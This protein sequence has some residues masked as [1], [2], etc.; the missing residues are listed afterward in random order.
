MIKENGIN[1]II[2]Y[3]TN[4]INSKGYY[5][6]INLNSDSCR[7]SCSS[8]PEEWIN[9]DMLKDILF[10]LAKSEMYFYQKVYSIYKKK[11]GESL[12]NVS[13]VP[14]K[15]VYKDVYD[16]EI[17]NKSDNNIYVYNNDPIKYNTE[18]F[19]SRY[20][21]FYGIDED[22]EKMKV[23]KNYL[24]G[25][26]W[27]LGYYNNHIHSNWNWHYKYYAT[28]FVSDL[29]D[30]LTNNTTDFV[31]HLKKTHDLKK[32]SPISS[33]QQLYLVLPR[34][35]LLEILESIDIQLFYRTK[36]IFNTC[37]KMLDEYYPN[38][39]CLEM[40]H[41]EYLWQSKVFLKSIDPNFIQTFFIES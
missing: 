30:Y 17:I 27:I 33:L 14:Y 7:E 9:L 39:I 13:N 26:Y 24:T 11:S 2:K 3:Y 6:L 34:D 35:S 36:R 4:V 18:G 23:C 22:S 32:S 37:S 12:E 20:Y 5:S 8:N 21:K 25:L 10:Q 19:K 40:I 38:N 41:K 16:L 29:F 28:P 31:E 15:N 1:V